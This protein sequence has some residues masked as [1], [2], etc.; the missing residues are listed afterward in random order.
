MN[1][2]LL[3]D[4]PGW[5]WYP[6]LACSTMTITMGVWLLFKRSKTV[7]PITQN[8]FH[9]ILQALKSNYQLEGRL[10]R[11]FQWFF[12]TKRNRNN[13]EAFWT[14]SDSDDVEA[15]PAL[16]DSDDV[17]AI[18]AL[19]DSNSESMCATLELEHAKERTWKRIIT[20]TWRRKSYPSIRWRRW[21]MLLVSKIT[22]KSGQFVEGRASPSTPVFQFQQSR[23]DLDANERCSNHTEMLEMAAKRWKP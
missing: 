22:R 9:L 16:S 20:P 3:K 1:V 12:Q 11:Q 6:I 8:S 10:E 2:D 18:P 4:N 15:L 5:W 19:S 21:P 14:L 7:S 13:V 17:E 23:Q